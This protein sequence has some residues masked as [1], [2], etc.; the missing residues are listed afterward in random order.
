VE[1]GLKDEG[2]LER[3]YDWYVKRLKL[4]REALYDREF[5]GIFSDWKRRVEQ[6]QASKASIPAQATSNRPPVSESITGQSKIKILFLT[7]N[8]T[9]TNRLRLDLESRAIDQALRK[10]EYRDRF[11]FEQYQ[12]VR[13]TDLQECLLRF[14][15]HIVHFSGHGSEQGEILLE[16]N[17][18]NSRPVSERALST[19]FSVLKDNIRCV[20]LNACYSERQAQAIAQHIDCVIGMTVAISDLSAL[21]FA[22]AFYQ[23]LAYGRDVKTAFNLGCI[24]IDLE[25]LAEQDTPKLLALI[26]DPSKLV[27][28]MG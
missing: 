17:S 16:D 10:A 9:D 7:A 22:S 27:F 20:F 11:E 24:Q 15:P 4:R 12:A 21:S 28:G 18:G 14:K 5:V 25:S 1:E 13:V 19:L 3:G 23:A 26:S 2:L 8:P 6:Y